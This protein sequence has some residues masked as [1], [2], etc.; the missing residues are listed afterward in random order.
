M[1]ALLSR[2]L[3]PGLPGECSAGNDEDIGRLAER[4][5]SGLGER[6]QRMNQ[7]LAASDRAVLETET[8]Q[9]KGSA[10]AMGYPLMTRQAGVVEA[11]VK[12]T[13]PQ[14]NQVRSELAVLDEMIVREQTQIKTGSDL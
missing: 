10:G 4:F 13:T 14:W 7:A 9:I 12:A 2:F 6:R 3:E 11:L 8:H 1:Q 5:L